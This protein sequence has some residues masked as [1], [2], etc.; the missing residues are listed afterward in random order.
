MEHNHETW[1]ELIKSYYNRRFKELG[2][3]QAD[4][5]PDYFAACRPGDQAAQK[6][7]R[8]RHAGQA[9]REKRARPAIDLLR[10][11]LQE[12]DTAGAGSARKDEEGVCT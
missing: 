11:H 3:A 7:A 4:A 2:V 6:V 9:L 1:T 10:S 8:V 5:G 12:H